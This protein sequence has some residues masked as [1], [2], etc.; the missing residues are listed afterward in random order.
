MSY[1]PLSSLACHIFGAHKPWWQGKKKARPTLFIS[2]LWILR[3]TPSLRKV[4][5]TSWNGRF[6]RNSLGCQEQV[7]WDSECS[8][9][10]SVVRDFL[11]LT[12]WGFCESHPPR[13]ALCV[14]SFLLSFSAA[15]ILYVKG[16]S[17]GMESF[18]NR[19]LPFRWLFNS[20][21]TGC[22]WN[23]LSAN[24]GDSVVRVVLQKLIQ[25]SIRSAVWALMTHRLKLN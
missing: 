12:Y 13:Q 16:T 15:S 14:K 19:F 5:L 24:P 9:L 4:G 18:P 10:I 17:G 25:A 8:D 21:R 20:G 23:C 3:N 6:A 7:S 2:Q 22:G 1:W 11:Y